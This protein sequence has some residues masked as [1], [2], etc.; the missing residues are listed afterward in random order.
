MEAMRSSSQLFQL[1]NFLLLIRRQNWKLALLILHDD[2]AGIRQFLLV[3]MCHFKTQVKCDLR[4]H[5]QVRINLLVSVCILALL[6]EDRH[7]V[8]S[9]SHLRLRQQFLLLAWKRTCIEELLLPLLSL[10]G[11]LRPHSI[12]LDLA[13][14]LQHV[15]HN[16]I[17]QNRYWIIRYTLPLLL[18]H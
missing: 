17:G 3:Q 5:Y 15:R 8:L 1:L 12:L 13:F 18:H 4:L 7:Q 16:V 14:T 9:C 11:A 6:N 2:C 10:I